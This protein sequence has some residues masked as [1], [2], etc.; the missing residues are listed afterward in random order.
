MNYRILL[1]R[2]ALYGIIKSIKKEGEFIMALNIQQQ[3][4]ANFLAQGLKSVQIASI[5]GVSAGYISQ[6]C[7]EEGP[8]EFKE[9]VRLK[10]AEQQEGLDEEALVTAKYVSVEHKLLAAMEGAMLGAEL[11]AIANALK[12][13]AERQEKRAARKAG[14]M[15]PGGIAGGVNVNVTVLNL[16]RHAVPEYELN[17]QGQ[18]I[19]VDGQGLAP[20]SSNS[21]RQ[22]FQGIKQREGQNLVGLAK[23][24]EHP[25]AEPPTIQLVDQYDYVIEDF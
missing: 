2:Q 8:E 18:V 14:I 17:G 9:V 20:M 11:P 19:A 4:I 5:V 12:I 3:R 15:V 23:D 21:V 6:L 10:A 22:M 1:Q 13:V 25:R 16:P 7:S 24:A